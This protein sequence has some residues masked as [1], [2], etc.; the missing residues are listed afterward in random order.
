MRTSLML[1]HIHFRII[2]S[3]I[4]EY[5]V[6]VFYRR[7][8]LFMQLLKLF[9]SVGWLT[10]FIREVDPVHKLVYMIMHIWQMWIIMDMI[11]G[12]VDPIHKFGSVMVLYEH[13]QQYLYY[14]IWITAKRWQ[15]LNLWCAFGFREIIRCKNE[16]VS[17]WLSENWFLLSFGNPIWAVLN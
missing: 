15:V 2:Y 1:H 14:S 3:T 8:E 7:I 5:D 16:L 4:A 6:D 11:I 13:L 9:L 12:E 17:S 10:I